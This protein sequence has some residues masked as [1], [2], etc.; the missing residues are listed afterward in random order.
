MKKAFYTSLLIALISLGY[1]AEADAGG[2]FIPLG[3]VVNTGRAGAGVVATR[4]PNAIHY[5]PALIANTDGHQ[6]LVDLTWAMLQFEYQRAPQT[7]LNGDTTTYK[8]VTNEAPGITIPQVLFTTDFGSDQFGLGVGLFPPVSAPLRLPANG[9]QR[10]V[11]VDFAN[12]IAFTT[13]I[14]FAWRPHPRFSIGAGIQNVT[15]VFKGTGISSTYFGVLASPEDPDMDS[16]ITVNAADYFS[17]SANFGVWA[18]PVDG[19]ELGASFQLFTDIQSSNG[20]FKGALP[21]H[22]V[23]ERSE[24]KGSKMDLSLSLPWELRFG[25]RY[26]HGDVFD[27]ELDAWYSAWSRQKSINIYPHDAWLIH[28]ALVDDVHVGN[29]VIPRNMKDTFGF[30]VGSDW[31]VLPDQL[32]LRAGLMYESGAAKDEYFSS[33]LYDN[34]KIAPTIGLSYTIAFA[35]IDFAF[36]HV[37]QLTKTVTNGQYV[38]YNLVYPEKAV[39]TNNGKYKLFYDFIGLGANLTFH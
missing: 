11:I 17:P 18:E 1:T 36:A 20:S 23:Y 32:T 14:A 6:L 30:S 33:F 3:G 29:F 28:N 2:L 9:P 37:H 12:T 8:K 25:L 19:F 31:N 27:I 21:N 4:D 7:E 39:A 10:Y 15:F 35:R 13:E 5:N 26:R 34:H 22:Y 24:L 16:V 38:Q